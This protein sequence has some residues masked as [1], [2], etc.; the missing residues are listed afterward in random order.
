MSGGAQ[1]MAIDGRPAIDP[2]CSAYY[3]DL[4]PVLERCEGMR[5]NPE[6][7]ALMCRNHIRL[8]A[9]AELMIPRDGG[10]YLVMQTRNGASADAL[11]KEISTALLELF[12]GTDCFAGIPS[13]FRAVTHGE[14]VEAGVGV[15]ARPP[16][17]AMPLVA[18]ETCAAPAGAV[19]RPVA[20]LASELKFGFLPMVNMQNEVPSIFQ[21]GVVGRR[22]GRLAFGSEALKGCDPKARPWVDMAALDY[23]LDFARQIV[24]TRFAAAICTSVSFETLAWSRGRQVYQGAL[25]AAN[26]AENPFVIVKIDD[27][28][29]GTPASRLAEIV[30]TVRPFVKRV[31]VRLPGSEIALTQGGYIGAA[32]L[33]LALPPK[34]TPPA[35]VRGAAWL[36]RACAVQNAVSCVEGADGEHA[37]PL[38]RAAGIRFVA[39]RADDRSIQRGLAPG[40]DMVVPARAA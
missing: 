7:M 31:F 35:I 11:A 38:L 37:M 10:F 14:M 26:V 16:A 30:A 32:G 28:P 13:L 25:R 24:P 20:N 22:E 3:F 15:T 34:A 5:R 9:P 17:S 21:C 18:P 33:C 19:L 23:S 2:Q 40:S 6:R 29:P 12:F 27:V 39:G 4:A 36:N 1:T 8:L